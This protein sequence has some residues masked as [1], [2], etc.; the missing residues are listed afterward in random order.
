MYSKKAYYKAVK[1]LNDRINHYRNQDSGSYAVSISGGN[2]KIGKVMNVSLAP[3]FTCANC[4]GCARFCYDIKAVL[5]YGNV[6]D[7]R[8][9][10]TVKAWDHRAEYFAE[11]R[12]ALDGRKSN[13]FFRWHVAGDIIDADYFENMVK[14]AEDYPH[15]TFWTY[16]KVYHIVNAFIESGRTI[17]A[18]LVIM[19][20]RWD[21]MPMDNP[22]HFPEFVCRLKDGNKDTPAEAFKSMYKCPGNCDLC[23]AARRGCIG[24]ETSY[25][26]EH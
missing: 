1:E 23:K 22:Y 9:R 21:G 12:A 15:F 6:L 2:K 25:V 17:P 19:F 16:T 13:Y 4:S 18:N 5:Q 8:A 11:I 14:I 24:G 7:A 26:D 10:N 3:V 20:S